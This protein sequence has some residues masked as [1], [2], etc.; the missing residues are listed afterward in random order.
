MEKKRMYGRKRRKAAAIVAAAAVVLSGISISGG[1]SHVRAAAVNQT[2]YT[3]S[4]QSGTYYKTI[5]VTLK[6]K[7]GYKVY[8]ALNGKLSLKKLVQSGKAKT[9]TIKKTKTLSIY[10][11]K[12]SKK[13]TAAALR[14]NGAK[15]KTLKYRYVIQKTEEKEDTVPEVSTSPET[16]ESPGT[17]SSSESSLDS[18]TIDLSA[19]D[20]EKISASDTGYTY[21]KSKKNKLQI[22][23]PGTYTI[24]GN[25]GTIDGLILVDLGEKYDTDGD[26]TDDTSYETSKDAKA[27]SVH[28]ILKNITLTDSSVDF[29]LNDPSKMTSD[30]GLIK[31]KSSSY[32]TGVTITIQDT[33]NLIDTGVTG[34]NSEDATD[35]TY[36]AA[37][38][39]KKTPLAINGSGTLVISSVNGNGI[40]STSSLLIENATVQVGTAETAAGHNGITAKTE[41]EIKDANLTVYA[42]KDGLK[43]TYDSSDVTDSSNPYEP[44]L[45][46]MGGNLVIQTKDGDGISSSYTLNKDTASEA[47]YGKM[48][49]SPDSLQIRT[50]A[51]VVSSDHADDAIHG[52]GNVTVTGGTLLLSAADDGIYADGTLAITDGVI[53]VTE[54]YEGLEGKDIVISGGT[55]DITA[56]DDGLNSAGGNSSSSSSGSYKGIKAGSS[57]TIAGGM[58]TIDTVS[59]GSK[60]NLMDN[61]MLNTSDTDHKITISGGS[62]TVSSE[63]DGIDS[64]GNIEI[65]GGTTV[66]YGP[67]SGGN[68]AIDIGDD[69]NCVFEITGGTLWAFAGTSDMA[70]TPT[71]ADPGFAA[72]AA[73]SAIAAGQDVT[74]RDASSE[75]ASITLKKA[76]A[77]VIY[78][79]SSMIAG[80]S[81]SFYVEDTLAGTVAA[82]AE[83]S[84]NVGMPVN[85]APNGN[86]GFSP[87]GMP[88]GNFGGVPGQQQV[89]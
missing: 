30:D 1:Q 73:G 42:V 74:I 83:S 34:V 5:K 22:M 79:S 57:L 70:V 20:G 80:N 64:N 8:Y 3:L 48:A 69:G 12:K 16:T 66:V 27:G 36:P 72:F 45:N 32:L 68:G 35:T 44:V 78:Y 41:L 6:A 4:K 23:A 82:A 38:L 55:M 81:Y 84:G 14:T 56:S 24:H 37:V 58:I 52:N 53:T 43:T 50:Q 31:V 29:A 59:T 9:I 33:V 63:G 60:S 19:T 49:I 89:Q 88:D 46:I 62:V 86:G 54:S 2:G 7:R 10:C 87:G 77:Y 71:R 47:S 65:T 75:I 11:V 61:G 39:S 85:G 25:G 67:S 76:A 28:L 18:I 40:K 17:D 13:V 21:K 51:S 26:G 15:A